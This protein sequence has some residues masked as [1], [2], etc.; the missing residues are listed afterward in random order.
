MW[1]ASVVNIDWPSATGLSAATQ[2]AEFKSWLDLAVSKKMNAVV[3]QIRPTADSFWP[4]AKEPWSQY[5]TGTQGVSPGYDPMAFMVSEAHARNLEFHAWFNPYRIA[6]TEDASTLVASHPARQNPSWRFPYNGKLYYNPGIPAVRTFVEDAMM[7]AVSKYDVD[8][9][10]WD[11]YF[12][13]YPNAGESIPDSATFAQYGGGFSNINDWRRNNVDLLVQEMG[14]RIHAAKPW[15]KF[16]VSPFGIWR[17]NTTDP[18]GSA[19]SGLQSYDAIYADTR[20]WVQQG[21]IDYITPQIYWHIGFAVADYTELVRWWSSVVAPTSVQLYVGQAAY[22]AGASGQSAEWQDPAELSDHLTVNRGYPEVKGDI[23]FSAKDIQL[24]RINSISTL[25]NAHYSKPALV[26]AYGA[27]AAPGAPTITTGTRVAN[28]VSLTWTGSGTEYA[29]YRL[30]AAA[31]SCSFVD[32]ANLIKTIRGTSYT[33][34]TA[35]AGT[36]Y[37]YYLSALDRQ[38]HESAVS[39]GKTVAPAGPFQVIVDGPTT[40]SSNWGSSSFS[41]QRYGV[42]YRFANP[43][44]ASDAAYFRANIPTAGNYK[45]EIWYPANSGYN[46]STPHVI[47]TATGSTTVN[48]DQRSNGGVWRNLGTFSLAAGDHDV[49]GVSRWT[50][51]TGYVIADA[52]RITKI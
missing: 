15:V 25:V 26:P 29:I 11:D 1:I 51:T 3:V 48:V 37:T 46:S 14:Q 36:T 41:S 27:G 32:A 22:R 39:T 43:V 30:T 4:G 23:F 21:W 40:A 49:L 2:Q 24:N 12:Y 9:V 42:D 16:G 10:H 19:T 8:G 50:S 34:T 13:P 17:N 7:D 31:D 47:F 44:S 18:A 5:L 38:H 45:V 52:V 28:G 20:K 35:A 6:M 33:D